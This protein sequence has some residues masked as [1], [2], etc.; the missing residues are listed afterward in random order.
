M[1]FAKFGEFDIQHI[2]HIKFVLKD[3]AKIILE[4]KFHYLTYDKARQKVC[5]VT[6]EINGEEI[7]CVSYS[8]LAYVKKCLHPL[9]YDLIWHK[10][11]K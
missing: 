9:Q 10:G 6:L 11:A 4:N 8:S 2:R 1:A 7:C 3:H 5:Y